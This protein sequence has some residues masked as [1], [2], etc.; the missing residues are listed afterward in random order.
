MC[1]PVQS[2][3]SGLSHA[4]GRRLKLS[5]NRYCVQVLDCE[6]Q[7]PTCCRLTAQWHFKRL[8]PLLLVFCTPNISFAVLGHPTFRISCDSCFLDCSSEEEWIRPVESFVS[9]S[10]KNHRCNSL[11]RKKAYCSRSTKNFFWGGP[12]TTAK[13]LPVIMHFFSNRITSM[14]LSICIFTWYVCMVHIKWT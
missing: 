12:Q 9:W 8:W 11:T 14:C 5:W 3:P 4:L 1:F 7:C 13:F 10:K 6:E 2:K